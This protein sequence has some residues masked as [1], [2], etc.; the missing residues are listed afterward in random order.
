M[1]EVIKEGKLLN[2]KKIDVECP[3][4]GCVFRCDNIDF[5]GGTIGC[6]TC[7]KRISY[8]STITYKKQVE[9]EEREAKILEIVRDRVLEDFDFRKVHKFMET[10]GWQWQGKVPSEDDIRK[11]VAWS[12]ETAVK[13]KRRVSTGGIVASYE[14]YD[15]DD[16]LG[17]TAGV[18]VS[19]G[20]AEA[21]GDVEIDTMEEVFV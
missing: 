1:I 16:V 5:D 9:A 20:L 17:K 12:V 4:C 19:F 8:T 7:R 11:T 2:A 21:R 3:D 13:E 18:I 15:G 14:E 10:V 6:P